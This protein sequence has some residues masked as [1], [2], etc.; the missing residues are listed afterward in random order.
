MKYSYLFSGDLNKSKYLLFLQLNEIDIKERLV[1]DQLV[2]LT[3]KYP[4]QIQKNIYIPSLNLD[5]ERDY[6]IVE[7][8]K[9]LGPEKH[10]ALLT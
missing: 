3:E 6:I 8:I 2:D 4:E 10:D 5:L 9:T 1:K 7:I